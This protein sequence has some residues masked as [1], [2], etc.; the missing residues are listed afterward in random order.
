MIELPKKIIA[1]CCLN[2]SDQPKSCGYVELYLAEVVVNHMICVV[3]KR[4][5]NDEPYTKPMSKSRL[6]T[7]IKNNKY[8]KKR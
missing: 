3:Y 8:I 6:A 1:P 4:L 2:H 7:Y 5:S